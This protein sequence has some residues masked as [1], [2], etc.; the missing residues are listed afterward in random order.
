MRLKR[1]VNEIFAQLKKNNNALLDEML[2][3]SLCEMGSSS[4]QE[5]ARQTFE[6]Q[7]LEQ[8]AKIAAMKAAA[9][10]EVI[11]MM[12]QQQQDMVMSQMSSRM[13]GSFF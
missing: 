11:Q 6:K 9:I 8:E 5:L 3:K 13:M 10:S 2:Q 7:K 1:Q 12:M 4:E